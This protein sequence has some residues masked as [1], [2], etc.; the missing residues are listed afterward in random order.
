MTVEN[1]NP[2]VKKKRPRVIIIGGGFG[3]LYAAQ[4]LGR[5]NVEVLL[6]DKR[7]FHL[8]QPLLY[9][10]ATGGLSPGDIASPL[11]AV[12]SKYKN[13]R[14]IKGEVQNI[15]LSHKRV[16]LEN[17]TYSYDQLI[18]AAGAQHYYFGN[19]QWAAKAPGLKT[20]ED[21][22]EMRRRIFQAFENAEKE[23]DPHQRQA[24]LNFVIIGGG[25][26]GVELAGALAE[27]AYETLRNDFAAMDPGET[28]I[29]LIEGAPRILGSYPEQLSAKARKTLEKL[30]VKI[31]T[32]AM[33]IDIDDSE[34]RVQHDGASETMRAKTI[35][36][37]AGV[38]MTGLADVLARESGTAQDRTGRLHVTVNLQ[39]AKYPEVFVIGDMAYLEDKNGQ[40]LPGVAPVAMQQGRYV[41][42][43]IRRQ[44][45]GKRQKPF[46]Y[47][48][49]GSLA[50]IGRNAAV[51]D[52]GFAR[53]AGWP[54]WLVWI[55]V[56]IAYL[57]E[58]ENRLLVLIQWASNYLTRKKGARLI[59]GDLPVSTAKEKRVS[60]IYE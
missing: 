51:A 32:D 52:F 44:L 55:F 48:N 28:R 49:K 22:L 56:H 18:V 33:V 16:F 58:Y 45:K 37:G 20:I 19:D 8:F 47:L 41:A 25:P 46:R 50:V 35:L 23:S 9:Q 39:L 43:L 24:W 27:L 12:V 15:D 54:A 7:N 4:N 29:T 10:V 38:K 42:K 5:Q 6:I 3:G 13:I 1:N 31:K 11:R 26:T 14:V 57:I 17:D 59:T 60:S 21:A 53:L 30:G 2:T 40:A 36:W 34:L